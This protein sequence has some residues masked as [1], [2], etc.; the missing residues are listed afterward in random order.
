MI[1]SF[2]NESGELT[3]GD[4]PSPLHNHGDSPGDDTSGHHS[5]P[6]S[7]LELQTAMIGMCISICLMFPELK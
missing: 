3:M 2:D 1:T 7:T 5:P 4:L 6:P